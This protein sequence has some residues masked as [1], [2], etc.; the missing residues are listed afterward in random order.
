MRR[1]LES[2]AVRGR[3]FVQ[4]GLR[5]YWPPPD[6]F[7]WMQEQDMRWHMMQEI[8][9]RGSRAVV[10]DAIAR[11]VDGCKAL[12]LSVDIDVLDPGFAPGT[13][14]PE[15]GGMNPAD[16]L[17]A[18]RQICLDAPVVAADIVEVSPPYDHADTTINCAH[19]V[20]MEIF[21][22]L[23]HRRRAAAR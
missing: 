3:N 17:R 16:L 8:W 15:P 12:Y 6:V 13:G 9:E 21:A 19:R 14:T 10:A 7:A 22:A 20:A 11:A 1:L 23:A 2:G 4:V 5:G 18:V